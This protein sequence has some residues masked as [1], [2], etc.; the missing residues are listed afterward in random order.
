MPI[1]FDWDIKL[2]V[3]DILYG[4]GIDPQIAR[5]RKPQLLRAA[6]SALDL[7]ASFI[8]PCAITELAIVREHRHERIVLEGGAVFTSRQVADHL[9]GAQ[10]VIAAVCTIGP[11]LEEEFARKFD[12]DPRYAMAL[13]G[14][15]NAWVEMLAQHVC[16]QIAD[17]AE[18][19]GITASTPLSPGSPDW[20]VEIGQ[21]QIFRWL[22]PS[23]MGV[24]LTSGGMMLP[25][26]S[27]SLIVGIGPNM[28]Q[29]GACEVCS[30]METCRYR[31]A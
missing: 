15:G 20:P 19:D 10:S 31:H 4:Q 2:S 17:Q 8:H 11:E 9:G 22:D 26:K 13:D 3:D 1:L 24:S 29:T 18:A 5:A 12:S 21:P 14:Y 25:K 28:A 6:E 23:R 30:L 7:G 16:R 27:V